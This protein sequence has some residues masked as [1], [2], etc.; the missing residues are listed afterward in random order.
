MKS[1][2]I[3]LFLSVTFVAL[4]QAPQAINYQAVARDATNNLIINR[5]IGI[6]ISVLSGS[7]TG[8]NV[9]SETHVATT[10]SSG[11]FSI[12]IGRGNVVSGNFPNIQWYAQPQF[13]KIEIDANGGTNYQIVGTSQ[14]LS[15][16]YALFAENTAMIFRVGSIFSGSI[17]NDTLIMYR[18]EIRDIEGINS[19]NIIDWIGGEAESITISA[20]GFNSKIYPTGIAFP[21]V[22]SANQ[23]ENFNNVICPDFSIHVDSS[24]L[25]G[26]YPINIIGI[27]Q[28]GRQK[29]KISYIQIKDCIFANEN[30][31]VGSYT[32]AISFY[33]SSINTGFS[34]SQ[35]TV[36]VSNNINND[37]K[38]NLSSKLLNVN[39]IELTNSTNNT[40]TKNNLSIPNFIISTTTLG[41]IIV[42]NA[43]VNISVKVNCKLVNNIDVRYDIISGATN[44]TSPVNLSNLS[45]LNSNLKG[46][47]TK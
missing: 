7:A 46:T 24:T 10:N 12:E 20:T 47:L 9:Y 40:Y 41:Q 3:A 32:G 8:T 17:S 33:I 15:V 36:V 25:A 16:P 42:Q 26:I 2:I 18:P 4:G 45:G 38:I 5:N 43:V 14:F 27:N 34:N 21:Y 31:Y 19:C 22:V 29:S 11:I 44:V 1:I 39:N 23:F 6:R 30:G 28:R 37:N 35:D 13:A